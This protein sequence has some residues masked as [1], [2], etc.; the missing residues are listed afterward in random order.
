MTEDQF[1]ALVSLMQTIASHAAGIAVNQPRPNS[2]M[3]EALDEARAAFG[4]ET[5]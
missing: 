1:C 4:L 5:S 3:L 2:N